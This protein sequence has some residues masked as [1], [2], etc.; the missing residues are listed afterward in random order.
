MKTRLPFRYHFLYWPVS[1]TALFRCIMPLLLASNAYAQDPIFSQFT[2]NQLF[3]NPAFTGY[4]E[5]TRFFTSYRNQW[6]GIG[7]AYNSYLASVDVYLGRCNPQASKRPSFGI[8]VMAY[9][10]NRGAALSATTFQ[11]SGAGHAYLHEKLR[12]SLGLQLGIISERF[13][14]SNLTFVAQY[15][16]GINDPLAQSDMSWLEPDLSGGILV[17]YGADNDDASLFGIG[18]SMKHLRGKSALGDRYVQSFHVQTYYKI[19]IQP[20]FSLKG[21]G[22]EW[23]QYY[24][25]QPA[26]Q[27]TKQGPLTQWE[28]GFNLIHSPFWV[29]LWC[30]GILAPTRRDALIVNLGGQFEGFLIQYSHDMTLFSSLL[31][32]TRGA[33]EISL[34]ILLEHFICINGGERRADRRRL[35]CKY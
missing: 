2:L 14:P 20:R 18:M 19:P 22:S 12:L 17:E 21:V 30:R 34:R 25:L 8:G 31:G 7:M 24:A 6:P 35:R 27:F 10:D 3:Y 15:Q 33:H 28:A 9:H 23:N 5:Q 4:A 29:G 13:D 11:V 1:A 26:F 16:T 32:Y